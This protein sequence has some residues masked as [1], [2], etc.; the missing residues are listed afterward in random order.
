MEEK[1]LFGG[2]FLVGATSTL[3]I[4]SYKTASR[5]CCIKKWTKVPSWSWIRKLCRFLNFGEIW[6]KAYVWTYYAQTFS[7]EFVH[8]S[9]FYNKQNS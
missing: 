7:N 6:L 9:H 3:A 1:G 8:L 5:R 4:L 2:R